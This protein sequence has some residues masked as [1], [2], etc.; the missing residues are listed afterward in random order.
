MRADMESA[1]TGFKLKFEQK[2]KPQFIIHLS[3]YH[4]YCVK[5]VEIKFY[6][7]RHAN[8]LIFRNKIINLIHI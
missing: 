8:L 6:L 1:P 2:D 5:C 3:T 4:V 7:Q